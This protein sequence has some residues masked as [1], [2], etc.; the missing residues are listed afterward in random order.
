MLQKIH[1]KFVICC[2]FLLSDCLHGIASNGDSRRL[3]YNQQ[4]GLASN[5]VDFIGQDGEGYLYFC[6]NRGLSIFDG[7]IFSNYNTQNTP[8]FSNNLT[9]IVELDNYHLLIT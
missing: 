6:T 3:I 5:T 7:N 1:L 2:L 9:V 8:G 4:D